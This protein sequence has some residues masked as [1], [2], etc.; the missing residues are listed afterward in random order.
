MIRHALFRLADQRW[1]HTDKFI[2]MLEATI[3]LPNDIQNAF[4]L[5]PKLHLSSVILEELA[6]AKNEYLTTDIVYLFIA[7]Y[8]KVCFL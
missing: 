1:E 5:A 7:P 2:A 8:V 3:I 6:K 4:P